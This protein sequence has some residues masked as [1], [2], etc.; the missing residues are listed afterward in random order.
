MVSLYLHSSIRLHG[1]VLNVLN[2]GTTS[3]FCLTQL[4]MLCENKTILI[5][6]AR[7]SPKVMFR[8][9]KNIHPTA[10]KSKFIFSAMNVLT[11][12]ETLDD[13]QTLCGATMPVLLLNVA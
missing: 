11:L 13:L 12:N 3:P 7:V 10:S 6:L 8:L 5:I 4:Q 1:V 9:R 2:T